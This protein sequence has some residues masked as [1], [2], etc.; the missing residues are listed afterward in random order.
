MP[1]EGD[2]SRL[3]LSV[4]LAECVLQ[5]M[6]MR[7]AVRGV[8]E[9]VR[10][11]GE[12]RTACEEGEVE[13]VGEDEAECLGNGVSASECLVSDGEAD[14]Q[15][16]Q[17]T[18]TETLVRVI[19]TVQAHRR[20][21]QAIGKERGSDGLH[22]QGGGTG[23]QKGGEERVWAGAAK[24]ADAWSR[25]GAGGRP[26]WMRSGVVRLAQ[27]ADVRAR[28][29]HKGCRQRR[30]ASEPARR[31]APCSSLP[32]SPPSE[33]ATTLTPL[34]EEEA[35]VG[36]ATRMLELHAPWTQRL[37]RL[38]TDAAD[39]A[40]RRQRKSLNATSYCGSSKTTELRRFVPPVFPQSLAALRLNAAGSLVQR[41]R[42]PSFEMLWSS[43][44]FAEGEGAI[45][46]LELARALPPCRLALATR[47][48]I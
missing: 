6:L 1:E 18:V 43:R 3:L 7:Q 26:A 4:R 46:D 27:G 8:G 45:N 41:T 11:M 44:F 21:L 31:L 30:P 34:L 22:V 10:V 19:S 48:L 33:S 29:G 36:V 32:A 39:R 35:E 24:D 16:V 20:S 14:R 28:R 2:V 47:L 37:L 42:K 13:G 17:V 9:K 23:E 25:Q 12:R 40:L 38:Q 15:A 5:G